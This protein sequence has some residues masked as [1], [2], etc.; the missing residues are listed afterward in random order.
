[1][2]TNIKEFLTKM[3]KLQNIVGFSDSMKLLIEMAYKLQNLVNAF[4]MYQILSQYA[5]MMQKACVT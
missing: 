3:D 1:M 2:I 5:H 4:S